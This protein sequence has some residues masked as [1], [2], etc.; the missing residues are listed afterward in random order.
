MTN[1][2]I[3]LIELVLSTYIAVL[4]LRIMLQW[5]RADFFNPIS[6][7]VYKAT[8]PVIR[9]P[10]VL[11]PQTRL[12]LAAV[13][14]AYALTVIA[15]WAV[16]SVRAPEAATLVWPP[17]LLKAVFALVIDWTSLMFWL[18]LGYVLLS[19]LPQLQHQPV[20]RMLSKICNPIVAPVRQRM[21]DLGGIDLSVMVVMIGFMLLRVVLADVHIAVHK[22]IFGG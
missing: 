2:T 13:L 17:L 12:N 14:T 7:F 1:T 16:F 19:W 10:A 5:V 4:L 9:W 11:L 22:A 3:F 6:Q 21:P 20:G 15:Q 8:Q 18:L